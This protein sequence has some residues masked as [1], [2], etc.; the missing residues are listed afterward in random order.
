M[1][2][3]AVGLEVWKTTIDVQKHFN[4]LSLRV[5]SLAVTVLGAFLGAAG[6]ALDKSVVI[7]VA[8]HPVSL[9]GMVLLGGLLCWLAFA[10]M[11]RLWYHRLLRAAVLHGR[12]VES[13]L[14]PSFPQ[15]GLTITID[16]NSPL[17]KLRAGH[18][19]TIFYLAVSA[20]LFVSA[21]IALSASAMFYGIGATVS[22]ICLALEFGTFNR[23]P[24]IPEL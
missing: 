17:W 24:R 22:G 13:S 3:D 16:D 5:R 10:V 21:G 20:L 18:R 23:K 15:I 9:A 8:D 2:S 6:Y 11:D 19:L 4:D 1:D 12:K 7:P 14:L